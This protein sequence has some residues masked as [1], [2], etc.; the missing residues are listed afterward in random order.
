[1]TKTV[2]FAVDYFI[3][4][5]YMSILVYMMDTVKFAEDYLQMLLLPLPDSNWNAKF[6]V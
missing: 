4:K 5:L 6:N 1:M 3:C 2:K